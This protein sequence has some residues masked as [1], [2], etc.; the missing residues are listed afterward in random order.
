MPL[1]SPNAPPPNDYEIVAE[2]AP[3]ATSLKR[4]DAYIGSGLD[5]GFELIS[6]YAAHVGAIPLASGEVTKPSDNVFAVIRL[7]HG[8]SPSDLE[9]WIRHDPEVQTGHVYNL[10]VRVFEPPPPPIMYNI[11]PRRVGEQRGDD[12]AKD[13]PSK[14]SE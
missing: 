7:R 3:S 6:S 11:A 4:H 14:S 10:R 13:Q 9:K 1:D 2:Y 12:P 5:Q 8:K